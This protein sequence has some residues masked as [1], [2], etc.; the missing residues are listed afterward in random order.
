MSARIDGEKSA[1]VTAV[2]RE[3]CGAPCRP[4]PEKVP[5][6][7]AIACAFAGLLDIAAGAFPRF[8]H[9][10]FHIP[11]EVLPGTLGPC[12]AALALSAGVLLLLLAPGL[13]R[14]KRR[15]WR[16]AVILLPAGAVAQFAYRHS[17]VCVLIAAL[18]LAS[19]CAIRVNSPLRPIPVAAG[20]SWPASS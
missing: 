11:A 1:E 20:G 4:S 18:V 7:L 6:L 3:V 17:I 16:A 10:H 5:S 9:S 12:A 14:R 2:S 19:C 8:R 13:R 15:A